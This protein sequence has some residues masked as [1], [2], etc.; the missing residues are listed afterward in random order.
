VGRV[1]LVVGRFFVL[2]LPYKSY[3]AE[4]FCSHWNPNRVVLNSLNTEY[5]LVAHICASL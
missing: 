2:F 3:G 4:V 5:A 1:V